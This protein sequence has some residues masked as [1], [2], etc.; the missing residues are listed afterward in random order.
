MSN[1]LQYETSPYLLQH[2]GNPVD[3]YPWGDEAFERA[4]KEQKP[5]LVSIGYSA[6]HWCHVM[7]RESFEDAGVASFMNEHFVNIK[8]DREEHPDVDHLYMDALQAMS[9]AGGWPLNM[10]VTPDRKPFYG[11]TYFPPRPLYGRSSWMEILEAIHRTWV[12]KPEEIALQAGQM[13]RH[14]EQASLITKPAGAEPPGLDAAAADALVDAL[15]QQADTQY[16]G[17]GGAPKFPATASIHLLLDYYCLDKERGERAEAALRHALLSLD[18]MIAGGIYDQV[19]GGF[20]RYAT[21]KEWLVPH[22]EK[23][24]YDN[25]LLL[26]VLSIAFQVTGRQ[27]YREVIEETMAFCNREL[28]DA[29]EPGFFCA[30]DADS[31]GVE[32]KFY[33]WPAADWNRVMADAHPALAAW[34]GV[35]EAGNWEHTNILNRNL[36]EEALL[37]RYNLDAKAWKALLQ[38]GKDTLMEERAKRTRPGTDEKMLLSWNALRNKAGVA[39]ARALDQPAYLEE[40]LQHMEWLLRVFRAGEGGLWHVCTRGVARIPAKL[41]DY[42]Y[43]IQA[44]LQLAS[45][46][47]Q[48]DYVLRAAGFMEYVLQHFLHEDRTFFYFSSLLQHDVPVRKVEVYDGA[49]PSANAVMMENLWH[50][51]N[52]LERQDWLEQSE[53][54]MKAIRPLAL[55]YPGSFAQWA[56]FMQAYH[57]GWKQLIISGK[58]AAPLARTWQQTYHPGI[59]MLWDATGDVPLPALRN[60]QVKGE[61]LLYLC[62]HFSCKAPVRDIGALEIV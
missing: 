62:E 42:A 60:K 17:F 24:L 28:R 54:M 18:Q 19:G 49:T 4:E 27:H 61:T 23:M 26:S 29:A 34:W 56:L 58:D 6:C 51:G 31:E 15:L 10:F 55:R 16:G 8:V 5:V 39:V 52:L 9:G 36:E 14:L 2:A 7:E 21:D 37:S 50:L 53:A 33:V 3:W 43:V 48:N 32:G 40:A 12:S 59:L 38:E 22:F 47:G 13:V 20:A 30:L 44:L 35:S 1:K 45:A 46:S 41:D 11:G 25:A 57:K